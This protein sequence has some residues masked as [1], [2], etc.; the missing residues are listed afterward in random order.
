MSISTR[1]RFEVFQRD[2]FRCLYCG[3]SSVDVQ[4]EVEHVRPRVH[5]GTDDR[6]NLV[7]SCHECNAGKSS[8]L[9]RDLPPAV[10]FAQA[11]DF[12][13]ACML[14]WFGAMAGAG[15]DQLLAFPPRDYDLYGMLWACWTRGM[16]LEQI[17]SLAEA[18]R[19][20]VDE[21]SNLDRGQVRAFFIGECTSLARILAP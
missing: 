11:K 10:I 18:T 9:V 6:W 12:G 8:R 4:L 2:G 14:E 5:S 15:M 19:R 1:L 20:H 3:R 13:D 16:T 7:T 17:R 21:H